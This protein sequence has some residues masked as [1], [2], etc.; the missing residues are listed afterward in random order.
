[1]FERDNHSL[2][3][4]HTQDGNLRSMVRTLQRVDWSRSR[5]CVRCYEAV[6]GEPELWMTQVFSL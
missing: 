6:A 1:M 4:N 2:F 3:F 5:L